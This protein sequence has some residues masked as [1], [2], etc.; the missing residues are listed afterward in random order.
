M[1]H[2]QYYAAIAWNAFQTSDHVESFT[3][4]CD[5]LA[6]SSG[7]QSKLGKISSQATLI[8]VSSS[9]ISEEPQELKLLKN[10]QQCQNKIDQQYEELA[11]WRLKIKSKPDFWS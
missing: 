8:E 1:L 9:M 10:S 4:F 2:D 6:M 7:S 3:Q 11:V 5:C